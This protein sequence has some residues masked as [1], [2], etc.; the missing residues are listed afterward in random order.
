MNSFSTSF[1]ANWVKNVYQNNNIMYFI[2]T[3]LFFFF[4]SFFFFL[5]LGLP[6]ELLTNLGDLKDL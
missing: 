4:F 2:S 5:F 3:H 1:Y 6:I